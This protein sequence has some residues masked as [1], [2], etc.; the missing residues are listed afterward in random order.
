MLT[1]WLVDPTDIE[2]EQLA[3]AVAADYPALIPAVDELYAPDRAAEL[4]AERASAKA[5]A[6][7]EEARTAAD[8]FRMDTLTEAIR[9]SD[10]RTI[11]RQLAS[12]VGKRQYALGA[13]PTDAPAWRQLDASTKTQV[14]N[15]AIAHLKQTPATL[16][17]TRPSTSRSPTRSCIPNDPRRSA[18]WIQKRCWH[19]STRVVNNPRETARSKR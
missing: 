7:R 10:W 15:R 11:K 12:P 9:R 5:K 2:Q 14:V 19:G 6:A 17:S 3:R 18:R 1:Y 13:L 8:E 4:T 16:D